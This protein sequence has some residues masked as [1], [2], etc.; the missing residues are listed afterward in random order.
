VNR[1]QPFPDKAAHARTENGIQLRHHLGF[2][3]DDAQK[4]NQDNQQRSRRKNRK[5]G[6]PSRQKLR[7]DVPPSP[8]CIPQERGVIFNSDETSFHDDSNLAA[9]SGATILRL[10]IFRVLIKCVFHSSFDSETLD[11]SSA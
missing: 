2:G 3:D 10:Y 9:F 8:K 6:Q 5:K 11:W 4:S 1:K 7:P